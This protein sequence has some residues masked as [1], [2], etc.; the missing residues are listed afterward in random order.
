LNASHKRGNEWTESLTRH[1]CEHAVITM[2]FLSR[3]LKASGWDGG[4]QP[5]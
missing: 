1:H 4:Y 5:Q 2:V 3:K